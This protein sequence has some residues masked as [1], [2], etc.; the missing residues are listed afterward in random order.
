MMMQQYQSQTNFQNPHAIAAYQALSFC[1][2]LN[3]S[4]ANWKDLNHVSPQQRLNQLVR[5]QQYIQQM[6]TQTA[7]AMAYFLEQQQKLTRQKLELQRQQQAQGG[8]HQG[9]QG[10]QG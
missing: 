9:H 1:P 6:A 10:H 3:Q 7:I 8:G 5:Q 2:P 4:G